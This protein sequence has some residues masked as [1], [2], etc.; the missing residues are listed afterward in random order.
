MTLQEYGTAQS[1]A[2]LI[3]RL[4]LCALFIWAGQGEI[5][6][7]LAAVHDV[8]PYKIYRENHVKREE[9]KKEEEEEK[10][11]RNNMYD[12]LVRDFIVGWER[13]HGARQATG[14]WT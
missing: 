2:L 1:I 6:R 11:R 13:A 8:K 4:L 12:F 3:A 14:G 5:R 10:E 7:Q 9:K